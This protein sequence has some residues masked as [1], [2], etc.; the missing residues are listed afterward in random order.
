MPICSAATSAEAT[1]ARATASRTCSGLY[2]LRIGYAARKIV[3]RGRFGG[4]RGSVSCVMTL[5][6]GPWENG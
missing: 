5:F 1:R 2:A 4:P 6:A 3:N